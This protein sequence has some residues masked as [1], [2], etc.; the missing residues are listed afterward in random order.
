MQT[1]RKRNGTRKSFQMGGERKLR[2]NQTFSE[3]FGRLINKKS[4]SSKKSS[5]KRLSPKLSP[6]SA[7]VRNARKNLNDF[8][9]N[10]NNKILN[11]DELAQ[12]Q[13]ETHVLDS[14]ARDVFRNKR[15]EQKL[16]QQIQQ[17]ESEMIAL[18]KMNALNEMNDKNSKFKRTTLS[19][20]GGK[21]RN[22]QTK[23]R[24]RC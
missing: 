9:K 7:R 14:Q 16:L 23:K 21:R 18:N 12:L 11:A 6:N 24:R 20:K 4:N 13:K 1:R 8:L 5:P 17:K 3:F 19:R 2:Q 15:Q 10:K 22:N